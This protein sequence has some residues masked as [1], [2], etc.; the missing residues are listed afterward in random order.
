MNEPAAG[1]H[2]PVEHPIDELHDDDHP[3]FGSSDEVHHGTVHDDAV[4]HPVFGSGHDEHQDAVH[5]AVGGRRQA[6]RARR[7]Q[8]KRRR[9][10]RLTAFLAVLVIIGVVTT[11]W[12]LIGTVAHRFQVADYPGN[13][14]GSVRIQVQP[15]DTADD[16]AATLFKA[17]VV[18]S[19]RAFIDA[20]KASGQSGN[21]QPGVYK[22]RL[23]ASGKAAVAAILDPANRLVT[24]VTIPEGYTVKQILSSLATKTGV[25]LA[26]LTSAAANV[27]DLGLPDGYA[28]KSAEG[29]LFPATYDFNPD[30]SATAIL[31][32]LTAQ[33]GSEVARI[34]FA[35]QAKAVNLTPY[36]ALIV[37]SLIESEAKFPED[38]PKIARVILNRIANKT[39]IGIDAS[40][41]YGVA[42]S[43]KDPNSTTYQ[44][45]SPYNVRE[46]LG[47]P[48]TPVSNPGEAS[49]QAA[50]NPAD[51]NWLYYVVIDKEGHHLFTADENVWSAAQQKCVTNG[52][53]H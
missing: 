44:E 29:F 6:Q 40:N 19:T 12:L 42:L 50:V 20:A 52:W 7:A 17:G 4:H 26:Q 47:L 15:G 39:P 30:L 23:Q 36:Q 9:R 8:R 22:V 51:G 24:K 31:Q 32:Q 45:N 13:G 53:C 10:H 18:K 5:H 27:S 43:G 48:P 38:R 33:F 1:G 3:L 46:H 34:N 49:L 14:T 25:P 28:A 37:A 16:I 41:R 21:I 35:A 2:V 11:S